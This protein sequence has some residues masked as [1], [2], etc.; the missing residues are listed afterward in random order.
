[1]NHKKIEVEVETP[2]FDI[3]LNGDVVQTRTVKHKIELVPVAHPNIQKKN[4]KDK[5]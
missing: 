3:D 2:V 1:M 4:K 5:F